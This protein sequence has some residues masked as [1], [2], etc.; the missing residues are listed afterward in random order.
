MTAHSRSS[1]FYYG[2]GD[3]KPYSELGNFNF[4]NYNMEMEME[5]VASKASVRL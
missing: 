3:M 5:S 1:L 2:D 4:R